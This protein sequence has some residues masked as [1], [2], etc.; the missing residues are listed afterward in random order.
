M[1]RPMGPTRLAKKCNKG[2]ATNPHPC[3]Y[4]NVIKGETPMNTAT[5]LVD[6]ITELQANGKE[7]KIT[8]LP[9]GVK[10]TRKMMLRGQKSAC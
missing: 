10:R 7:P 2:L 9:S 5:N 6:I 8:V 3:Y 1:A 4:V